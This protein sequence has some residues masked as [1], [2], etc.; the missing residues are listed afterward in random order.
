M[1]IYAFLTIGPTYIHIYI[2][3]YIYI[4]EWWRDIKDSGFVR[5]KEQALD[6]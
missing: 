4:Y 3:K 2:Y 1:Y 5:A 6:E